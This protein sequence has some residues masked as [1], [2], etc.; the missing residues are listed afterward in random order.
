MV[1]KDILS[2]RNQPILNE[3]GCIQ[4]VHQLRGQIR[5]LNMI[6]VPSTIDLLANTYMVNFYM[7]ALVHHKGKQK[8]K[9]DANGD[10][11]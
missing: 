5:W 10:L 6:S 9:H 11:L 3:K 8:V 7:L 2:L 1:V 4:Q